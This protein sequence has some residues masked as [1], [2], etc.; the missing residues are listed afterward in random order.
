MGE[1]LGHHVLLAGFEVDLR[2]RDVRVPEDPLDVGERQLGVVDHGVGGGVPQVVEGPVGAQDLVRPHQDRAEDGV[3]Q[4]P[5]RAPQRHP[6]RLAGAEADA[7]LAGRLLVEPQ[8]DERVRRRRQPLEFAASLAVNADQLLPDVDELA[9]DAEEFGGAGAG[10]DVEGEDRAVPVAGHPREQL[11][12]EPVRDRAGNPLGLLLSVGRPAVALV[13]LHRVVVGVQLPGGVGLPR[14][15]HRVDDR[16][17]TGDRLEVVELL[18]HGQVVVDGPGR[19]PGARVELA[20]DD[21]HRAGPWRVR[22]PSPRGLAG[23]L[24][25]QDEVPDL[26]PAGSFPRVLDRPE[27]ALPA[28]Q[29]PP[30]RLQ[31]L[32]AQVAGAEILEEVRDCLHFVVVAVGDPVRLYGVVDLRQPPDGR[33][34]KVGHIAARF[35]KHAGILAVR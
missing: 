32:H 21:V 5:D 12:E 24:E 19:V 10:G 7:V 20:G 15:G 33:H 4:R 16:P 26:R 14:P 1:H 28:Q 34:D 11:V 8:P 25:P 27:E 35:E 6:Q 31:R 3:V 13:E 17:A 30:V 23:L 29:S 2:G 9:S 18:H 22:P